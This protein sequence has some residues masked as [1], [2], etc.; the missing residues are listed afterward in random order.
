MTVAQLLIPQPYSPKSTGE[1]VG[2]HPL[3]FYES[4]SWF[5][6]ELLRHVRLS[7]VIGEPCVRHGAF[8]SDVAGGIATL[9]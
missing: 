9:L 7:G 5:T 6:T 2:R 1:T 3:N 4:P 8:V